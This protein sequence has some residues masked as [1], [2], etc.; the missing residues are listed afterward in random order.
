MMFSSKDLSVSVP[1]ASSVFKEKP[2]AVVSPIQRPTLNLGISTEN[3]RGL[4]SGSL[5]TSPEFDC[6]EVASVGCFLEHNTREI[7]ADFFSLYTSPSY[8]CGR[9]NKVLQT[10]ERV[11][12]SLLVK[13]ELVYKGML[14]KLNLEEKGE[15]VSVICTVATEMFK[16]GITNWGRIASLLAFGAVVARFQ[17]DSGRG[18]CVS[19]VAQQISSYLM[20]HQ[21]EWLLKNNSWDG[22]VEFFHVPNPESSVRSA[23]TSI[24]TVA[25][26]GAVLA[27]L[28]R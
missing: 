20:G 2:F 12:D 21:K 19:Q 24:V 15:D 6:D 18:H 3:Q 9:H 28:T 14:T 26:I 11:V 4:S 22:F 25:G 17:K 13:H 16:D 1:T 23:L 8:R 27:Y 5:P 10:M 7:I